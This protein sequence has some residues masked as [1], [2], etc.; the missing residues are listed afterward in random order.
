MRPSR[1]V[2][3][4]VLVVAGGLSLVLFASLPLW[5]QTAASASRSIPAFPRPSGFPDPA[6][7]VTYARADEAPPMMVR[8]GE[9]RF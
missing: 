6:L 3:Q 1:S 7:R 9:N 4:T 5:A 8:V 2:L